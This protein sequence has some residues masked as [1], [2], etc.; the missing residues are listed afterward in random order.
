MQVAQLSTSSPPIMYTFEFCGFTA[1]ITSSSTPLHFPLPVCLSFPL[2]PLL[3][4][5]PLL[6]LPASVTPVVTTTLPPTS[7]FPCVLYCWVLFVCLYI[8]RGNPYTWSV[9]WMECHQ[10]VTPEEVEIGVVM[11]VGG[12]EGS[13]NR[14]SGSNKLWLVTCMLCVHISYH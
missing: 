5:L 9:C 10:C 1:Q 2:S 12:G 11:R 14:A 7:P 4:S 13:R 6:P 8:L 3:P